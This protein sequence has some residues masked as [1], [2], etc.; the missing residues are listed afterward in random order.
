MTAQPELV[1]GLAQVLIMLN[2]CSAE[3]GTNC[4]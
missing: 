4:L 2:R 3:M 1:L